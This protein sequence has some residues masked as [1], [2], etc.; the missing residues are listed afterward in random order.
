[1][2][3]SCAAATAAARAAALSRPCELRTGVVGQ[4]M[5]RK[6]FR[7]TKRVV[8]L[9][10]SPIMQLQVVV[11]EIIITTDQVRKQFSPMSPLLDDS[12]KLGVPSVQVGV[13][14]STEAGGVQVK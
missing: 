13:D 12:V 5:K 1:M 11:N 7:T 9:I 8:K 4:P 6:Y 14:P 10:I 2:S 3:L